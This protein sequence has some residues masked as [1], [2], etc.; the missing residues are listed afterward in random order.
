[1]S[2]YDNAPR[3][4]KMLN[5]Q[6]ET[7]AQLR[8]RVAELEAAWEAA[9]EAEAAWAEAVKKSQEAELRRVCKEL[10]GK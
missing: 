8:A 10:E 9:W 2:D 4:T 5:Q 7:I 6:D 1:M 3:F